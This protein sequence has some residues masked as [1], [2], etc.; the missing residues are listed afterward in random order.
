MEPHSCENVRGG[1]SQVI[2]EP[3]PTGRCIQGH[4]M[5]APVGWSKGQSPSL[6][7]SPTL[8]LSLTLSVAR[9]EGCGSHLTQWTSEK[10]G[11]ATL[12]S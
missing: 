3:G 7:L 11:F 12:I 9:S 6:A 2:P 5:G 10:R 8:T 1:S 4:Q